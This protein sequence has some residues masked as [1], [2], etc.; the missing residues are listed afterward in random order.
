MNAIRN[1]VALF[2]FKGQVSRLGFFLGLVKVF[3]MYI[4]ICLFLLPIVTVLEIAVFEDS[5]GAV[6]S[7]YDYLAAGLSAFFCC[8]AGLTLSA[9]RCHD[10]N[11][12]G[13]YV[14]F[15]PTC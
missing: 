8:W 7:F 1:I 3:F 9:R 15:Y 12:S 5:D 13:W 4:V 11:N 6:S 10:I 2:S 14:L